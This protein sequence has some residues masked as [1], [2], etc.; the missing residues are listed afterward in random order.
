MIELTPEQLQFV[1]AQVATGAFQNP[2]AVVQA[3]IELLQRRAAEAERAATIAELRETSAD[4]QSGNG[5]AIEDAEAAIR[6][7]YGFSKPA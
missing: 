4:M 7:K 2:E 5:R 6:E 3:G 1:E